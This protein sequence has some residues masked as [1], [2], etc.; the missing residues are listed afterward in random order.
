M[1]STG[2]LPQHV[3]LMLDMIALAFQTD[4]TRVCT[5][6][7]GNAVSGRNFSF[8]D[9]VSG[10]HHDTSHH[11][12]DQNKLAAYQKINLRVRLPICLPSRKIKCDEGR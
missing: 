4:S 7:F 6:M 12:N 9:G 3:Q 1:G 2:R 11:Q 5:F 10:G 8:L